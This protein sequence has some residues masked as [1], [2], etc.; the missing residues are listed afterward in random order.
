MTPEISLVSPTGGLG[1]ASLDTI[2][3][4]GMVSLGSLGCPL[5][6]ETSL[7]STP[8]VSLVLSSSRGGSSSSQLGSEAPS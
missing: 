1:D 3:G 4:E 6:P 5:L 8:G 2:E 7:S